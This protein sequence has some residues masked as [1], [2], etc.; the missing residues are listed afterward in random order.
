MTVIC[1]GVHLFQILS[2]FSQQMPP[3]DEPVQGKKAK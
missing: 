1:E 3:N 2:Q